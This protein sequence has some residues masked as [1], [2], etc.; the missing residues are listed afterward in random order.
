VAEPG[1]QFEGS[2]KLALCIQ[3][4]AAVRPTFCYF[5]LLPMIKTDFIR[6]L[7]FEANAENTTDK[8]I[9]GLKQL[10]LACLA[11]DSESI[12]KFGQDERAHVRGAANFIL[13]KHMFEVAREESI[14]KLKEK[15]KI[16]LV[17]SEQ[18]VGKVAENLDPNN[19]FHKK[20]VEWN[21]EFGVGMVTAIVWRA[22][23]R[24][25]NCRGGVAIVQ[26]ESTITHRTFSV[27]IN[28]DGFILKFL[29]RQQQLSST[30]F[31]LS[32]N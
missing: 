16:A 11:G 6:I 3:Q 21:R 20:I 8:D 26:T 14:A 17:S 5:N 1:L 2:V 30:V 18:Y 23:E 31:L 22:D 28:R 4:S 25:S 27:S 7:L 9:D 13:R 12:A 10:M 29:G 19:D 24:K 32:K 15:E